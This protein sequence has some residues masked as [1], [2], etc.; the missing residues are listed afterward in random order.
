MEVPVPA[1]VAH[2]LIAKDVFPISTLPEES[3]KYFLLGSVGPDLPYYRNVFG[4]AIG[5]FFEDRYNSESPGFYT[6]YGD[7]FHARTVNLFPMKMLETIRKDKDDSTVKAQ[8]LAYALG[9]LTHVAADQ[10]IHP[11]VEEYAEP[12]YR[13]GDCRKRHRRIEV[14][15]DVLLYETTPGADFSR[16]DF[17]SWF[18]ISE[19][20]VEVKQTVELSGNIRTET[21]KTRI[22]TPYWFGSFIQRAFFES[23]SLII[24]GDEADK[25]VKGF[26]SIFGFLNSIGP[27]HDALK[28]L[29]DSGSQEAQ[30]MRD[31]FNGQKLNYVSACFD[32][33]KKIATKYVAAGREFFEAGEISDRE[34]EQFL[35]AVPDADLTAPLVTI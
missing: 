26:E 31:W 28:N 13:S 19:E 6:G 27:Y 32:P 29:K 8:K 9:Y 10:H 4:S 33:A 18:D 20:K 24:D 7:H 30:A 22:P 21:V 16:T 1:F 35:A 5:E 12:Y 23:Y 34:R 15:E 17:L 25:W 14:Y 3:Q 11:F 2:F